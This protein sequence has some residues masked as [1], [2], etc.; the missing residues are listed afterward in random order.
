MNRSFLRIA[1]FIAV[2]APVFACGGSSSDIVGGGDVVGGGAGLPADADSIDAY[3]HSLEFPPLPAPSSLSQPVP[4]SEQYPERLATEQGIMRCTYTRK[5][6]VALLEEIVNYNPN[7]GAIFPGALIQRKGM[8][9]G[10]PTPIPLPRAPMKIAMDTVNAGGNVTTIVDD[11]DAASVQSAM[12]KL[13]TEGQ[14]QGA[15]G[16]AFTMQQITSDADLAS[17]LSLDAKGSMF[18]VSVELKGKVEKSLSQNKAVFL[19]KLTQRYY[20]VYVPPPD[21]P[22]RIFASNVTLD[23]VKRFAYGDNIPAIVSAVTYGRY[24]NVV[25]TMSKESG[26]L[27]AGGS[28]SISK[29]GNSASLDAS[30]QDSFAKTQLDVEAFARGGDEGAALQLNGATSGQELIDRLNVF[31]AKTSTFDGKTAAVPLGWQARSLNTLEISKVALATD[32][33]LPDCQLNPASFSVKGQGIALAGAKA[34]ETGSEPQG[35]LCDLYLWTCVGT[36][37]ECRDDKERPV[38]GAPGLTS[39]V[40]DNKR[41]YTVVYTGQNCRLAPVDPAPHMAKAKLDEVLVAR[42]SSVLVGFS[43]V[44]NASHWCGGHKANGKCDKE[45]DDAGSISE[46]AR[47]VSWKPG[48]DPALPTT[49]VLSSPIASGGHGSVTLE[50]AEVAKPK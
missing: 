13:L 43:S 16:V 29:G 20:T 2:I 50:L 41:R 15:G 42:S 34:P 14:L 49:M 48:W 6:G 33:V 5:T 25:I 47:R 38:I 39:K 32:F 3:L 24:V 30:R 45:R 28:V 21:R 18:G 36:D 17:H 37:A 40:T 35:P 4:Y 19:M 7:A 12:N 46:D 11:F 8:E 44:R 22:S 9:N 1:S 26:S 10:T 27:F 23:D 31:L